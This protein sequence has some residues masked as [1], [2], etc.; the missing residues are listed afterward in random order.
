[1]HSSFT[2]NCLFFSLCLERLE[3]TKPRK[4]MNRRSSL[5]SVGRNPWC[6][7]LSSMLSSKITSRNAQAKTSKQSQCLQSR[8]PRKKKLILSLDQA[9]NEPGGN[10]TILYLFIFRLYVPFLIIIQRNTD[11]QVVESRLKKYIELE[12]KISGFGWDDE[13]HT[14]TAPLAAWE[15]LYKAH[16][17]NKRHCGWF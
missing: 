6:M 13:R 7:Q 12:K 3:K 9:D 17:D 14:V 8:L 2:S 16:K 4:M 5:G 11:F 15:A 10:K 1:V